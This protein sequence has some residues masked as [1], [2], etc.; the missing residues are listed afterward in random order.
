ML[1]RLSSLTNRTRTQEAVS[2]FFSNYGMLLVLLLL[3][4]YYAVVTLEEQNPRGADAAEAL[5]DD[6]T[7]RVPAG[8]TVLIATKAN[9]EDRIFAAALAEGLRAAGYTPSGPVEGTPQDLRQALEA[10]AAQERSVAAIA[11]TRDNAAIVRNLQ[12]Q[13]PSLTGAPVLTPAPYRWPT[14]LRADNI[15]NVANQIVV[16]AIIAVGM[17]MVIITAGIDLSVGSLIALSAV[18]AAYLIQAMGGT[19]A[20]TGAMLLASAAAILLCGLVGLFS[21]FVITRFRV[22]P[23]I[24]T[25]GVMQIASGLAY[26]IS[27]G[28]S[29]S[30]IPDGYV[31]L[32]RGADLF[33]LPNAVVL[34]ILIYAGAHV[35]M[36]RTTL[37]RY[38]YAV[39]GNEEAARL[40]GIRVHAVL[41]FVYVVAGLLAGLGGIVQA[42]QLKSGAPTYGLM[43]ELYVIAAVVIGGTSLFGGE[44][45]ILGT[46]IGAFIIAVIQ[47]G[48][49]LTGVESYTQKVVLGFVILG[50]VLLDMLKKRGLR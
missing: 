17:T 1:P 37:G 35:L 47:N 26:I 30:A 21:G 12:R 31:W 3:C 13:I 48:M 5:L 4:T 42:S 19:E 41:V 28:K 2:Q 9:E 25:L 33:S 40:S 7:A 38:I 43:Y 20:G 29:I 16:I 27:E 15:R 44:G 32:G 45:K 24:A 18:V 10:V 11:T 36:T 46:L 49:N 34:M 6:L 22:P 23:F 50:A 39:G 8:S 14:F